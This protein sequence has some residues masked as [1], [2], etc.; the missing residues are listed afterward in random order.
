LATIN[1]SIRRFAITGAEALREMLGKPFAARG[2]FLIGAL[3]ALSAGAGTAW[4]QTESSPRNERA[5]FR[6]ELKPPAA[7]VPAAT[8]LHYWWSAP[9]E[10]ATQRVVRIESVTPPAEDS[11]IDPQNGTLIYHW[12]FSK[13]ERAA[14][15]AVFS[16]RSLPVRQPIDPERI[17]PFDPGDEI[18]QKYLEL[19]CRES[20][21]PVVRTCAKRLSQGKEDS[22]SKARAAFA[23][24]LGVPDVNDSPKDECFK[25]LRGDTSR[26]SHLKNSCTFCNLCRAEG[27]PARLVHGFR[28]LSGKPHPHTWSEFYASP[29]GWIPVDFSL[30][31][32][33]LDF[34]KLD[35]DRIIF[36]KGLDF[37]PVFEASRTD[38]APLGQGRHIDYSPLGGWDRKAVPNYEYEFNRL[39]KED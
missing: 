2:S 38:N 25:T 8:A 32:S 17:G 35:T 28:D 22:Y 6:F 3:L 31:P 23:W 9:K 15:E 7:R 21:I 36:S 39:P 19:D 12:D 37:K 33:E 18:L 26:E 1:K 4:S 11:F 29:Y 5:V 27:I 10:W 24:L 30:K 16:W 34:G 14:F 20:L 13:Y